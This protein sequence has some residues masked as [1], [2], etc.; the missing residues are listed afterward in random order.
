MEKLIPMTD[1]V[2][3]QE[4]NI[5]VQ[6]LTNQWSSRVARYNKIQSYAKFLKQPRELWM[7]VP[8]DKEGNVMEKPKISCATCNECTCSVDYF[9][10]YQ[11]AEDRCLFEGFQHDFNMIEKGIFVF[12][13]NGNTK[14]FEMGENIEKLLE[15]KKV[16]FKLTPTALKKILI[17]KI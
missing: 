15:Y 1:F 9:T 6:S 17:Y 13:Y 11:Q 3:E 10:E 12:T 14:I 4:I 7:F 2:L 5:E 8:C 16:E